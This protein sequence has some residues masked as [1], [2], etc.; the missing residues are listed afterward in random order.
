MGLGSVDLYAHDLMTRSIP[1][2]LAITEKQPI[3]R[4]QRQHERREIKG[5]NIV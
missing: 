4:K 1:N 5:L 3:A 2:N